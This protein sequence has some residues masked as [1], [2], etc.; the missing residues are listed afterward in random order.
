MDRRNFLTAAA[1][2]LP[3]AYTLPWG[4]GLTQD[5]GK[6]PAALIP[7]QQNPDNL[8]FPFTTLDR[9]TTLNNLFY[10]RSHFAVPKLDP[11]TW[12]LK[13]EGAVER[14]LDLRY[15]EIR[16]MPA[17]TLTATL[18]CAGNSRGFLVPKVKGVGWK[19]GAVSNADWIGVPLA[20]LLDRAGVKD[21]AIEVILEGA[22]AGTI[23]DG[24]AGSIHFARSLPLE[25][26]RKGNV[27]L[28]H[29]M[30][31]ADL[32][33]SHGFP[34][35]TVVPG[36]YGVASVKWL[37]R[38]IVTERPFNGFFQSID[39]SIFTEH[40]GLAAV[41]P[42][43]EMQVKAEVARP[44][45]GEVITANTDYRVH[46]AAWTGDSTIARV[47]VSTDGGKT[48]MAALLLGRAV[49]HAW[50]LWEFAWHTPAQPGRY[51]VMARATD[52]RGRT[53]PLKRDPDRR[54][55]MVNQI[56]P[57]EVAVKK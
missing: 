25:R 44:A 40:N 16:N 34:L 8:E 49:P 26:V 27:L 14:P 35:R 13:V 9:F 45:E 38:I 41:V 55:Y 43:T 33:A 52:Q 30:N 1:A 2:S 31:H 12:R 53:Q 50:Q 32:P 5:A 6:G 29:Q 36:W 56:L 3:L 42:I 19:L 28:A 22:D 51:E 11:A 57:V 54:N 39:Y 18:E 20:A 21:R 24:P 10:V 37:T 4:T 23:K 7:R 47:E 48:W 17:R 46:G 15:D